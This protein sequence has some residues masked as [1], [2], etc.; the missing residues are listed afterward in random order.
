MVDERFL[1]EFL[2]PEDAADGLVVGEFG[3][4]EEQGVVDGGFGLFFW[5]CESLVHESRGKGG[6]C[7]QDVGCR[8][9]VG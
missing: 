7:M 4:L 2:L 3:E 8:M 1:N 9:Q 6:A 5:L